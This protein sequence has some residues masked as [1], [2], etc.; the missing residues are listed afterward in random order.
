MLVAA[1][2][3]CS[4]PVAEAPPVAAHVQHAWVGA[5]YDGVERAG[6]RATVVLR[7][8][9]SVTLE[10]EGAVRAARTRAVSDFVCSR[11]RFGRPE[12]PRGPQGSK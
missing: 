6:D 4:A 9:G 1:M 10:P 3:A 5:V 12:P 2:F 7:E 8:D 11:R